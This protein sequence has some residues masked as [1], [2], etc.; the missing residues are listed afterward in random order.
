M[1]EQLTK[2][3]SCVAYTRRSLHRAGLHQIASKLTPVLTDVKAEIVSLT[4]SPVVFPEV[5]I[6]TD[7]SLTSAEDM[8]SSDEQAKQSAHS[9]TRVVHRCSR[10]ID[11]G[12]Q[13]ESE[14]I[15]RVQCESLMRDAQQKYLAV[16]E[17]QVSIVKSLEARLQQLEKNTAVTSDSQDAEA[18]DVQLTSSSSSFGHEAVQNMVACADSVGVVGHVS[19]DRPGLVTTPFGSDTL[20]QLREE[21]VRKRMAIKQQRRQQRQEAREQAGVCEDFLQN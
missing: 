15:T 21:H 2:V 13:T 4:S 11:V 1:V 16:L 9:V 5:G 3:A 14:V 6:Q 19:P 7:V 17:N 18:M 8:T 10:K 12:C 20:Q